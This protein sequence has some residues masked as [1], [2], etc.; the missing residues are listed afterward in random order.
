MCYNLGMEKKYIMFD[1]I[2]EKQCVYLEHA[3]RSGLSKK[4][5]C[6][7]A[8]VDQESFDIMFLL[9]K[10]A[11]LGR[12]R[13]FYKR[14]AACNSGLE[15]NLLSNIIKGSEKNADAAIWVL[16]HI[17]RKNWG[18]KVAINNE[19]KEYDVK[20]GGKE[21]FDTPENTLNGEGH[22]KDEDTD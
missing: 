6:E 2:E 20:I 17:N 21:L 5:A 14:M 8:Y 9:G 12:F 11:T 15:V 7:Y 13:Y 4:R 1:Y 16:A 18:E 3:F 10:E 19:K 22:G